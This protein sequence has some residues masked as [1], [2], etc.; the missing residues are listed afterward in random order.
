MA[1]AATGLVVALRSVDGCP[2]EPEAVRRTYVAAMEYLRAEKDGMEGSRDELQTQ[3]ACS[4]D[5][6]GRLQQGLDDLASGA[7][8]ASSFRRGPD[9]CILSVV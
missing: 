3:I 2:D 1:N 7:R 9:D 4:K 6:L 8:T 5:E